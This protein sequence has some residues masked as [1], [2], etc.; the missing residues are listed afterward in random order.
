MAYLGRLRGD[1]HRLEPLRT[2]FADYVAVEAE[3][4]SDET[5]RRF[6]T[7]YLAGRPFTRLPRWDWHGAEKRLARVVAVREVDM[8]LGVSRG[9][10]TS[11]RLAGVPLKSVLLAA[12]LKALALLSGDPCVTSC[13]TTSGRLPVPDGDQVAGLFLNSTPISLDLGNGTWL[14]LARRTCRAE[15]AVLPHSRYPVGKI[16]HEIQDDGVSETA[17]YYTHYHIYESLDSYGELKVLDGFAHETTSF[18][19]VAS[20]RFDVEQSRVR[21]MLSFRDTELPADEM[22]EVCA[23]YGRVLKCLAESPS[24]AHS[25]LRPTWPPARPVTDG[26]GRGPGVTLISLL[27]EVAVRQPG[28]TA[29]VYEDTELC[30]DE[31][32]QRTN[33]LARYLSECGVVPEQ[34]VAVCLQPGIELV[35]AIV[36]ILKAGAAYVPV[37]PKEPTER[38]QFF[39]ADA[40]CR[41]IVTMTALADRFAHGH[42][43]RTLCLD[44]VWDVVAAGPAE[45]PAIRIRGDNLAYVMYTSGTTGRPKG[46]LITHRNVVRLL[47]SAMHRVGSAPRDRWLLFH[48][49]SFDFS[50]WELWG[51]LL[52]GGLVVCPYWTTRS[53]DL[54]IP[55]LNRHLVGV[56]NLTPSAFALMLDELE[57]WQVE[58][59]LPHLRVIC[60]GGEPIDPR[61]LGRWFGRFSQLGVR[62]I[63]MY[64]ITETTVHSTAH[65]IV[66]EDAVA[67]RGTRVGSPLGDLKIQ[68]LGLD[69]TES[70]V[71]VAGEVYIG[72]AGLARGYLGRPDITADRFVPDPSGDAPACADT[73]Q[74]TGPAGFPT[75][76]YSSSAERIAR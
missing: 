39:V 43:H 20:F 69:G 49:A 73:E 45:P 63:N 14:D 5:S 16:K 24:G 50:V 27:E 40:D 71:G 76:R 38:C 42:G 28:A 64:G 3:V 21:L 55:Y 4:A 18:T 23:T 60:F 66:P 57:S 59:P 34:R 44:T 72:G 10:E 51:G 56:L 53:P 52:G 74:V 32:V 22:D 65:L 58:S 41:V 30:Y 11:A 70:P 15:L 37:D 62:L 29:V 9:L 68:V 48:A 19:L 25:A 1:V 31:L 33:Q 26:A 67:G 47:D 17:F 8:P 6:W 13:V 54:L 61:A 12:H 46:V 2:S 75:V 35:I 7:D 36:A